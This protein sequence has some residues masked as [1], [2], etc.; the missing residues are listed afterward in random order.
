M[1]EKIYWLDNEGRKFQGGFFI[2]CDLF[3]CIK[4][5][6]EKGYRVIG[7]KVTDSWNLEFICDVPKE[8]KNGREIMDRTI[9]TQ[10]IQ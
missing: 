2:R 5:F 1:K 9:Q 10:N 8:K 6:E 3:K 7:I 4:M